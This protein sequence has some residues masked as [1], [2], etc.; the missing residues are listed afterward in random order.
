M[1]VTLSSWKEL[2]EDGSVVIKGWKWSVHPFASTSSIAITHLIK[3]TTT[4]EDKTSRFLL[5][6]QHQQLCHGQVT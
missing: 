6:R 3:Q 1:V 2:S 4:Q 5:Y